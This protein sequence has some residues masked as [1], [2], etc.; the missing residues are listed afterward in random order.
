MMGGLQISI[1]QRMAL[2]RTG[3]IISLVISFL[4]SLNLWG[5]HRAVP[6][7]SIVNNTFLQPP[8]DYV[9]IFLAI[10]CLIGS[11]FMNKQ[12]LL[13]SLSVFIGIVLVLFDINRLQPW[14]YIYNAM[15]VIFI[16]YTGRVDDSNKYTSYFILLQVIIASLYFFCGL[17]Q[18]NSLFIESYF[19]EVISPLK[20][21]ITERQFI[22]I[23]KLGLIS[24]YI[25]MFI[26]IGLIVTP[27]RY[28]AITLGVLV[29]VFLLI[30]L[31]P[32]AQHKNY[33]LWFSNLSLIVLLILLFSGKTKQRYFSPIFLFQMPLFY[34]ILGL[35][36]I[37]PFFNNSG[38]WPDYLSSNFASGNTTS[39][40][41]SLSENASEKLPDNLKEFYKPSYGFLIFEYRK[42]YLRELNVEGFPSDVSF[43]SIYNYLKYS[44]GDVKEIEL[45]LVP[46]QKLL[47]KP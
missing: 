8:F 46:K 37:M 3:L 32:S 30:F 38:K 4:L 6:Y 33:A 16:F 36:V 7:A 22:F 47:L 15:L 29:H 23:K 27:V 39:A 42:W 10:F 25:L 14:F 17:S 19:S 24:P 5:G 21:F 44:D 1:P 43:N 20:H 9:F 11:L 12:R 2:I 40:I 31:F 34:L 13:I 35:F 26:G 18:L 41:I 45:Q 28:L